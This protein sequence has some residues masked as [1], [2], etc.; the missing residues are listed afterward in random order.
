MSVV[1]FPILPFLGE[2]AFGIQYLFMGGLMFI[3]LRPNTLSRATG[4]NGG[5]APANFAEIPCYL[6]QGASF[7]QILQV[8][9]SSQ[10]P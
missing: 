2:M 3:R 10:I 7:M 9:Y 6:Q 4:M 1:L 5:G 8:P